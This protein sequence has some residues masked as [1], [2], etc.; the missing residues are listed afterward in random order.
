[1]GLEKSEINKVEVGGT[2]ESSI[3]LSKS[4]MM[5]MLLFPHLPVSLVFLLTTN[6]LTKIWGVEKA[7]SRGWG[8][9]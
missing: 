2:T 8:I 7:K 3:H 1:M 6:H 5:Q 9:S 4:V